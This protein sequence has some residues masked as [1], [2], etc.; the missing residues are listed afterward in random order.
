MNKLVIWLSVLG[1]T[2]NVFAGQ[3][4]NESVQAEANGYVK[5]EHINGQA[6]VR[7][8]DKSEVKVQGNLSER[9]KE[10]IFE[11]DGNEVVIKVKVNNSSGWKSWGSDK[12]DDLEIYVPKMSQVYYSSVNAKVD[13]EGVKGSAT[14]DTVNGAIS[15]KNLAGRIR[16]E[17][18][19]GQVLADE[20]AGSVK[21]ETVNGD[22]RSKS[23]NGKKDQYNSV[24][25]D[26]DITS[27]SAQVSL[28]TVN[29]DSQLVLEQ[30]QQ[31][32]ISSVNGD[33]VA[34]MDLTK[35][36]EVDASSVGGDISLYFQEG[37]SVKFDIEAHADGSISNK[38]SKHKMQKANY[39]PSRWLEFSLNGGNARVNV[40]TVNGDIELERRDK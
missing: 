31:L 19:N 37:V 5:I 26:I 13:I 3:I 30:V 2:F 17:S 24:N 29:G 10:F 14:I 39:G 28:E 36:G 15:A 33:L 4:V 16:I 11:R 27:A 9:T 35:D 34:K 32:N 25:G 8:W 7:V 38:L 18:V 1:L 12:G 22:I 20:L 40:T 21:I 23:R 6:K